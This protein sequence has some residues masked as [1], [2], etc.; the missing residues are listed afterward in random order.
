MTEE[1]G[2]R[3]R[4][5]R[6]TREAISHAAVSLFLEHGFDHVS[7][8]EVAAAA[9]VSK[10]TVFN[11]FPTK[12]DLVLYQ[13]ADHVDEFATV[14]RTREP[15]EAPLAALR[16]HFLTDLEARNPTT[17]LSDD[18]RFLAFQRMIMST[19]SLQ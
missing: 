12:E 2:L 7:V 1:P 16:R 3:E 17:A 19:T 8:A 5:K 14:V 11:Y 10:M 13:I 4:K 18:P 15:G 9:D 6:R